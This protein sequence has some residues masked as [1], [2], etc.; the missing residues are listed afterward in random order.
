MEEHRVGEPHY[1]FYPYNRKD[2][3]TRKLYG[4]MIK[5]ID[6]I[7]DKYNLQWR[8]SG[9]LWDARE[10]RVYLSVA[11]IL[12]PTFPREYRIHLSLNERGRHL[13]QELLTKLDVEKV[14]NDYDDY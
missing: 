8:D 4:D 7:K 12:T 9:C 3:P 11:M 14:E 13:F 10:K 1:H 6:Q 2:Y 5:A